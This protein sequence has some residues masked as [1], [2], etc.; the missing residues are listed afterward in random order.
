[1]AAQ[2]LMVFTQ[3][4]TL[5]GELRRAEPAA[6]RYRLLHAPARL[7]RSAR[8]YTLRVLSIPR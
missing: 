3:V 4:L 5:T 8:R 6:L 1:L 2:D 7:V